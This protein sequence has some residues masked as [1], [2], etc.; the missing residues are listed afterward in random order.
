[1]VPTGNTRM[2]YLIEFAHTRALRRHERKVGMYFVT[3]SKEWQDFRDALDVKAELRNAR[4]DPTSGYPHMYI[5]GAKDKSGLL[6]KFGVEV[7]KS[8][9][10]DE[11]FIRLVGEYVEWQKSQAASMRLPQKQAVPKAMMKQN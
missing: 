11:Y 3:G 4:K 2:N 9:V 7:E 8:S 10:D 6:K 5:K 1:M